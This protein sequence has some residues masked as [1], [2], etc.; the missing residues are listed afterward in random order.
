[1][2]LLRFLAFS[3]VL[4]LLFVFPCF[5]TEPSVSAEHAVLIEASGGTVLFEKSGYERAPMA[6]TTKIMTSILAIE[7]GELDRIITV[8]PEAVGI[9]GSS[10]YLKAGEQLTMEELVYAVMLQS[11]NDAAAAIACAIDGSTDA[12][13][14]RMNRKAE[15]LGLTNTHFTNPHG[16]DHEQHYTTAYDLARLAAYALQNSKFAEICST[17]KHTIPQ[18]ETDGVRV[19]VNHNRLLKSYPQA[20]GVK[21]GY[22]KKSGRC[23]VSAAEKDGLRVIA[24]TLNAP[25]D[26]NDHREMLDYGFDSLEIREIASV[27]DYDLRVDCAGGNKTSI[28]ATNSTALSLIMRKGESGQI[29]AINELPRF[30]FAPVKRGQKLGEIVFYTGDRLLGA[31]DIVATESVGAIQGTP[32]LLDRIK[33]LFAA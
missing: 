5:G 11:A 22:T 27:G 6:S 29:R 15:E 33:S 1:M 2:S 24:V 3:L 31:V 26:W 18:P 4:S 19:L 13:A 20:I 25:D 12:F 32:S 8:A 7:S 30:V 21:T 16:L 17:P 10:V 28:S 9:E 14:E 23:L